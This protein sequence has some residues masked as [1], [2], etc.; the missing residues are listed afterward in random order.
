MLFN[1]SKTIDFMPNFTLDGQEIELISETRLLGVHIT[2]DMKWHT[3]TQN[4]IRRASKRL[5]ILRRLKNLGAQPRYLLDVFIK[6][7]R[8]ILEFGVPVWQGSVTSQDKVDLERV[9]KCALN[10]I[11]GRKYTSYSNALKF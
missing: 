1:P 7:I 5:W 3:N 10:I 8:S 9:Q 11:L 6:Q 4:I 2:S